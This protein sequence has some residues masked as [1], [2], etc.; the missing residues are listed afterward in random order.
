[1]ECVSRARQR[2]VR[3]FTCVLGRASLAFD[4]T[5]NGS[6]PPALPGKLIFKAHVTCTRCRVVSLRNASAS[7]RQKEK[8]LL[9]GS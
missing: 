1:M 7:G 3:G 9:K 5:E 6:T 2:I 4:W 8:K